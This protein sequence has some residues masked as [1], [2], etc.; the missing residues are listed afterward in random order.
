MTTQ[1]S[2]TVTNLRQGAIFGSQLFVT[3]SSGSAVRLGA[4][5]TGLPTTAGQ[6]I[7]NIPGFPLTGSPYGFFFADLDP[8][9]PGLDVL[10]VADDSL[11]LT[12][13]SLVGGTWTANG[14]VGT[15][16]DAY[17]G[18]TGV[19]SGTAVALYATR[20]GSQLVALAD[21]S[22][23]NGAFAG[24][25]SVLATVVTNAAFRGVALAPQP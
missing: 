12:K 20:G 15:A 23:Y 19:V 2:T 6:A 24:T 10:Y 11:G 18:L 25:P 9:T 21:S 8:A 13:Y 22:G 4:V 7:V 14:T 3:D 1:L 5:G 16:T 17:R